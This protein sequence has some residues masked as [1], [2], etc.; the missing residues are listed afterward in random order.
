MNEIICGDCLKLLPGIP[1][2]SIDLILTDPPYNISRENNFSSMQRY[3]SY[4]GIDFGE[5]DYDFDQVGWI[6]LAVRKLKSPASIVIWNSWQ[7]LAMISDV[8]EDNAVS[9]KRVLTWKK[10]NPMP[11]N[12]DRMFVSSFEFAVWGTKGTG[13]TFN[14]RFDNYETG[15][16]EYPNNNCPEHPTSKPVGLFKEIVTIL[17][18]SGDTVLDPFVGSG[19]TGIACAELGRN[20]IG[21]D[22]VEDYCNLAKD[23][24]VETARNPRL[25]YRG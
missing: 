12:R 8:L 6:P 16:F 7:N 21:V 24:I 22:F 3:N 10:S 11:T 13:W 2:S 4:T 15:F 14:R 23:R 17:T 5:W 18:N 1:D 9:V 19:T 20:F 25:F